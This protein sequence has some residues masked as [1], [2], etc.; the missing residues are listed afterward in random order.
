MNLYEKIKSKITVREIIE[1][2]CNITLKKD[3]DN[4]YT[5]ACFKCEG[6]ENTTKFRA[7]PSG[8]HCFD[9][10]TK[11]SLV[12]LVEQLKNIS[13]KDAFKYL[14]T[15]YAPE[16]KYTAKENR[17][18]KQ[19]IK[20]E[21]KKNDNL[22]LDGILYESLVKRGKKA[23]F[24]SEGKSTLDYLENDRKYNIKNI[25]QSDFFFMPT[26]K[27]CQDYLVKKFPK[28]KNY[29]CGNSEDKVAK[30]SLK[31]R[32]KK[33][34][35]LG[36]P[37]RNDDG[38]IVGLIFR[39]IVPKGEIVEYY[40]HS[41]KKVIKSKDL[42]RY[43]ST[44]GLSK[45][46]LF[47]INKCEISSEILVVEG[48]PDA[49]Y[50]STYPKVNICAIGQG[51]LGDSN[52]KSLIKRQVK[53][54]ILSLDNDKVK[55]SKDV[56]SEVG[57][58]FKKHKKTISAIEK[59]SKE[60]ISAF[61]INPD[62]LGEVKDIDEKYRASGIQ[63]VHQLLGDKLKSVDYL[64]GLIESGQALMKE[65]FNE[66]EINHYSLSKYGEF[67]NCVCNHEKEAFESLFI[68][69]FSNSTISK[70]SIAQLKI[71]LD[72][73][74]FLSEEELLCGLNRLVGKDNKLLGFLQK[75]TVNFENIF[76]KK[77]Q[78]IFRLICGQTGSG[79]LNL[80]LNKRTQ[81][82][83][84]RI[85]NLPAI[86]LIPKKTLEKLLI[87]SIENTIYL[88]YDNLL[89]KAQN[90][91]LSSIDTYYQLLNLLSKLQTEISSLKV[92]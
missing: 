26:V 16:E 37:Y 24:E 48:Y 80:K 50:L 71:L 57:K 25:K 43:D 76:D 8:F 85:Q 23:L 64:I 39:S 40:D 38:I 58:L 88:H 89:K 9:C 10:G 14:V 60:N 72:S 51:S 62:T 82:R 19:I 70:N 81:K 46:S 90:V 4:I 12:S 21:S 55:E 66:L 84:E 45:S 41:S 75:N 36:I 22:I 17:L 68:C 20:E 30:L 91:S 67:T 34:F 61:V 7:F 78:T 15:K 33:P 74:R 73:E 56:K 77:N 83:F 65:D 5:G 28:Q 11:G 18:A 32:F 42:K 49:T 53:S 27:K 1:D 13:N 54:I 59:L 52:I 92:S 47:N 31:G 2:L 86:N 6:S 79:Q 87:E 29:I 69:K 3:G 44:K 35:S 63:G